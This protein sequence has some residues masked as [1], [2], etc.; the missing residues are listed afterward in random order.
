MGSIRY[1][2]R[3]HYIKQQPYPVTPFAQPKNYNTLWCCIY[4]I[5]FF[6]TSYGALQTQ[7]RGTWFGSPSPNHIHQ[8]GS[9]CIQSDSSTQE[10]CPAGLNLIGQGLSCLLTDWRVRNGQTGSVHTKADANQDL[11]IN[12]HHCVGMKG[13]QREKEGQCGRES[14]RVR[15]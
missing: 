14:V 13:G 3:S 4:L 12:L 6:T 15:E 5:S 8:Q 9:Q 1:H 11:N 10:A 7:F 2:I